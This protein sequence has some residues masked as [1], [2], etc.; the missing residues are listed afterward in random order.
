MKTPPS[1]QQ[2]G[3]HHTC[4]ALIYIEVLSFQKEI[5][6]DESSLASST[7]QKLTNLLTVSFKYDCGAVLKALL[8][9]NMDTLTTMVYGRMGDHRRAFN[10]LVV[11]H[12]DHDGA[13]EH[14]QHYSSKSSDTE[15]YDTLLDVYLELYE[16]WVCLG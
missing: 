6:E 1:S 3:Q 9:A 2:N 11:K 13:L 15:L 14:C 7:R 8:E 10:I 16:R 4:L 12:G 5:E